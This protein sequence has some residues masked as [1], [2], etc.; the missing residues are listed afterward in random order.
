M[1]LLHQNYWHVEVIYL[2]IRFNKIQFFP[3][4]TKNSDRYGVNKQNTHTHTTHPEKNNSG[5]G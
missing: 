3:R 5:K 1:S 2:L 4:N